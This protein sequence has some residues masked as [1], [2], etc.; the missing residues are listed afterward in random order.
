MMSYFAGTSN[1]ADTFPGCLFLAAWA[2]GRHVPGAGRVGVS[3]RLVID[4]HP[5]GHGDLW[6]L[7]TSVRPQVFGENTN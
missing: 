5:G 7:T 3:R 1:N 4:E 6:S 2:A